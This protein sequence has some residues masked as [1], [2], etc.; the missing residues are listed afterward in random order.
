MLSE[1]EGE[2]YYPWGRVEDGAPPLTMPPLLRPAPSEQ[3]DGP[4]YL[5]VRENFFAPKK[6]RERQLTA[7]CVFGSKIDLL[8]NAVAVIA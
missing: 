4:T 8:P 6:H 1:S 2:S 3:K 7:S 5:E